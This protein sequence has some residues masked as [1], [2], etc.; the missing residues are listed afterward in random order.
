[1]GFDRLLREV[2]ALADLA[3]DEPVGDELEHLD[4]A[5]GG[6]LAELPR[7][8]RG[9]R[10]DRSVATGAT[11]CRSRFETAAVVAVAIE[12]LLALGGV[13]VTRIGLPMEPL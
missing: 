2:E 4:L 13:H 11:A 10:D 1:M 9:E 7:R 3:I 12:D 6:V 5:R 8:R